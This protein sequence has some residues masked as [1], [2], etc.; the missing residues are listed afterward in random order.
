MKPM[1][2]SLEELMMDVRGAAARQLGWDTFK[3][4]DREIREGSIPQCA[5]RAFLV[6]RLRARRWSRP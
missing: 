2:G 5:M 1:A 4:V 3:W 6:A